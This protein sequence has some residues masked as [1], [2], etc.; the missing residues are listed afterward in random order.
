MN[1]TSGINFGSEPVQQNAAWVCLYFEKV[2][3]L[4]SV[5][6]LKGWLDHTHT[7][8]L[9]ME[10]QRATSTPGRR[11]VEPVNFDSD[12]IRAW[13]GVKSPAHTNK[14]ASC[15]RVVQTEEVS[16]ITKI[17]PEP[18]KFNTIC[19]RFVILRKTCAVMNRL[20]ALNSGKKRRSQAYFRLA[21]AGE[22]NSCV[23]TEWPPVVMPLCP[24]SLQPSSSSCWLHFC[25]C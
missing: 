8:V 24:S 5:Q 18:I 15:S 7:S 20:V 22:A 25:C 11:E 17:Q 19:F 9:P 3:L 2:L 12:L 1:V 14:K 21:V 23:L 16:Y 4:P 10:A 6:R 13:L